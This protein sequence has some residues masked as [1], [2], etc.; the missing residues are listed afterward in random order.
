MRYTKNS[1]YELY[2]KYVKIFVAIIATISLV[3]AAYFYSKISKSLNTH[4]DKIEKNA[5][6]VHQN[7]LQQITEQINQLPLIAQQLID[8]INTQRDSKNIINETFLEEQLKSLA[9][10]YPNISAIGIAFDPSFLKKLELKGPKNLYAPYLIKNDGKFILQKIEK[11][12]DYTKK[13]WYK[14]YINSKNGVWHEPFFGFLNQTL[15]IDFG[16]PFYLD[17]NVKRDSNSEAVSQSEN[18]I[19]A[20]FVSFSLKKIRELITSLSLGPTG[21]GFIISEGGKFIAHPIDS[22]V[23]NSIKVWDLA[24]KTNQ[25]STTAVALHALAKDNSAGWFYD[26]KIGKNLYVISSKAKNL[27][28]RFV[29]NFIESENIGLLSSNLRNLVMGLIICLIVFLISLILL[30]TGVIGSGSS[31]MLWFTSLLISIF[32]AIGTAIIWYL[33]LHNIAGINPL[34]INYKSDESQEVPIVNYTEVEQLLDKIELEYFKKPLIKIPTGINLRNMVLEQNEVNVAGYL[35]QKYQKASAIKP[36]IIFPAAS[37]SNQIDVYKAEKVKYKLNSWNFTATIY[38]K[39]D[40][41]R[42]PFDSQ[43]IVIQLKPKDPK[44]NAVLLPDFNSYA[45]LNPDLLPG[46]LPSLNIAGWQIDKSYFSYY[47]PY[48]NAKLSKFGSYLGEKHIP[49]LF[50]NVIASRNFF[51][52]FITYIAPLLLACF[53]LFIIL[54]IEG[55]TQ[56]WQPIGLLSGLFFG[57][58]LAHLN[59]RNQFAIDTVVYLEYF[60][61]VVYIVMM[62]TIL[63]IFLI[64]TDNKSKIIQYKTGII[65]KILYWP[66]LLGLWFAITVAFFS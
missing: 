64:A 45:F 59:L 18:L 9:Q 32:F 19:G 14:S 42:Y 11:K 20:V 22:Y 51:D 15:Q 17:N 33:Q 10:H 48:Q 43:K 16:L 27:N 1:N 7:A 29:T 37:T 12:Y 25:D 35:W 62:L 63:T 36:G 61:L 38:N 39:F 66:V 52:P 4:W 3:T 5:Q 54:L 23:K 26:S 49:Q 58:V 65:P 41:S 34:S 50:F 40:Y 46:I 8:K 53:F 28:W 30:L 57:I 47:Q 44:E 56:V 21:Y 13:D 6:D 60:F 55:R 31:S 2:D 24:K